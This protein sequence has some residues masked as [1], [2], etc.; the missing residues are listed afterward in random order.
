MLGS[1][2]HM[3][4]YQLVQLLHFHLSHLV[5]FR[6]FLHFNVLFYLSTL[7]SLSRIS[8]GFIVR[9]VWCLWVLCAVSPHRFFFCVMARAQDVQSDPPLPSLTHLRARV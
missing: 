6:T 9:E 7:S 2:C 4:K 5:P 8:H 1:A 3:N